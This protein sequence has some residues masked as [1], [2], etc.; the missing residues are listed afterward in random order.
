[1]TSCSKQS[2]VKVSY[3]D[4]RFYNQKSRYDTFTPYGHFFTLKTIAA[5]ALKLDFGEPMRGHSDW[6][7][8]LRMN[9]YS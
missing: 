6:L 3:L 5:K 2:P 4:S 7:L 9:V 1:M 8:S